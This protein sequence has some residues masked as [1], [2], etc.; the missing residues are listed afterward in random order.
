MFQEAIIKAHMRKMKRGKSERI[1]ILLAKGAPVSSGIIIARSRHVDTSK[2]KT[3]NDVNLKVFWKDGKDESHKIIYIPQTYLNQLSDEK[4][5]QTEIDEWV[6]EI[7]LKNPSIN[8]SKSQLM[9]CITEYKMDINKMLLDFLRYDEDLRKLNAEKLEIGNKNG[10]LREIEKLSTEKEKI[11][12][13]SELSEDD[14]KS[15]DDAKMQIESISKQKN[16]LMFDK[17]N[18]DLIE[19]L[20]VESTIKFN[21]SNE[22]ND[23]IIECREQ[24]LSTAK[25]NWLNTKTSIIEAINTQISSFNEAAVPFSD[26]VNKLKDKIESNATV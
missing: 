11:V 16:V 17:E 4:E 13:Q 9:S 6:E 26:T 15:Y 22:I 10:I 2:R 3:K 8:K 25:E 24:I 21:F 14:I 12:A 19:N 7:L 18:L 1:M 5:N 20:V 23:K